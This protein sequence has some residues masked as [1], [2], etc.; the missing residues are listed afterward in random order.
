V[1]IGPSAALLRG[2]Q[3]GDGA[4]IGAHA[5]VTRDVPAGAA[6]DGVPAARPTPPPPP[7]PARRARAG[8]APR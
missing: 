4:Q 8:R 2:V 3:V 7:R 1:R 6:V 5:V